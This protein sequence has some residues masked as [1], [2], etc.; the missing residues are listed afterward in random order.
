MTGFFE[1]LKRR[2]VYRVAVAYAVASWLIIQISA[3]VFPAGAEA[4]AEVEPAEVGNA[5]CTTKNLSGNS[6]KPES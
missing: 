3:T 2:K 4:L 6:T 1:E 5:I